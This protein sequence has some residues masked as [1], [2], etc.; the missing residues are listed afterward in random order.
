[1][2]NP[3][4]RFTRAR[5][6]PQNAVSEALTFFMGSS[7]SGKRVNERS[8]L[9]LTTVYACVRVISETIASL[10][11]HVYRS[12]GTGSERAPDHPLYHVLH[13][14]PNGEMTAMQ[15][16]E[17]LMS[18]IL[19]WGNAYAQIIRNGRGQVLELYPLLPDRMRVDRD[20]DGKL[21]YEYNKDGTLF[22]LTPLDVLHV[23]GLGFDGIM[24][25]SPIAV[26][27]NALGL[28]IAA[29]EYGSR[30]FSNGATP[31]GVL[32]HP[33]PVKNPEALRASWQRAYGG[34]T[35]ANKVA[36]LEKGMRFEKISVPNNEAQFLESRKFQVAEICRIF[37]VPPHLVADLD[38]ATFANIEHQSIEFVTHCIRP[39]A[40]RWEQAINRALFT[41]QEK[42]VFYAA[43]NLDGLQRGDYKTRMEGYA[44]GRQNGWLSAND[45]RG[46]ENLNPI[47]TEDGGDI[48]A[49]NGNMIRLSDIGAGGLGGE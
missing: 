20:P 17:T 37:R 2:N 6:K 36:V 26:A 41:E 7:L 15:L 13:D 35:N 38:K 5:D 45:I 22:R 44:I 11:L 34:S 21:F 31:S 8:A 46:L 43:H 25:H 1:M 16:R 42:G 14:E 12:T 18:H 48:Y 40:V 47:P 30:F 23:P 33:G 49:V 19:L 39:W 4:T 9:Q 24:G 3:F 27:R 10:P 29:E 28:A 32:T